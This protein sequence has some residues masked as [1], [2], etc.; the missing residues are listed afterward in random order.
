[1]SQKSRPCCRDL[2]HFFLCRV[3]L[4]RYS[5]DFI[6]SLAPEYLFPLVAVLHPVDKSGTPRGFLPFSAATFIILHI[7]K[8]I[9]S[10]I[11]R[12]EKVF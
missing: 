4:D 2:N 3:S 5:I 8:I 1:M 7:C 6:H 10:L 9:L 12:M 11:Q